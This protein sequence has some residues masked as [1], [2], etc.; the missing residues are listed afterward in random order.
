MN[1]VVAPV[2]QA[3]NA[4]RTISCYIESVA[5]ATF[6]VTILDERKSPTSSTA[7]MLY[8]DGTK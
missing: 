3:K 7:A 2:Y 6:E 5:G 8:V 1:G 4:G